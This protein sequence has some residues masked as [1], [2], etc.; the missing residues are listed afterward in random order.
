[1]Q[2]GA[3]VPLRAK[4]TAVEHVVF[5]PTRDGGASFRRLPSFE[6]AVRLV[7]HLRNVEGVEQVSVHALTEVPL[8]FRAYYRV[9]VP[10]A[11]AQHVPAQH[12]AAQHAAAQH[13]AVQEAA[14]EPEVAAPELIALAPA[15]E[16]L[17]LVPVSP[18][19]A[20]EAE[21]SDEPGEGQPAGAQPVEA[22][23]VQPEPE[24]APALA[25]VE[26]LPV[27]V[28]SQESSVAASNGRSRGA[29][30]SLGFFA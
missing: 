5:F 19:P 11:A 24:T 18:G 16:P 27:Q 1:M 20:P 4:G 13:A 17:T 8:N 23:A 14:P 7:E 9:E 12:A 22:D 2:V 25:L 29:G 26:N 28:A 3:K 6:E 10:Q 15:G 30:N 21:V